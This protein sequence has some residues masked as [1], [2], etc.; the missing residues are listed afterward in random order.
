MSLYRRPGSPYWWTRFTVGGCKVRRST[1]TANKKQAGQVETRLREQLWGRAHVGLRTWQEACIRWLEDH[2]DK[3]SLDRDRSIIEWSLPHL[4]DVYLHEIDRDRLD[5]L[6]KVKAR[7]TSK[8]TANRHLSLIRA[9]LNA[10]ADEWGWITVAPKVPMFPQPPAEP[11]WL[12]R[13]EFARLLDY[14]PPHTRQLARFAVATGLRRTNIT[15]L[16]WSQV[17]LK[18]QHLHIKAS[19]AKG[20]K[21][22]PVPLTDSAL[23]ILA[24]QEGQHDVWVF[25]YQGAP[26]N[27]V[28]TKAWRKA[29]TAIGRPTLRFHDL[30]HTWASWHVQAG[31]PLHAL[32]ALGGWADLSMVQRYAHLDSSSL[33]HYAQSA[34]LQGHNTGT[35]SGDGKGKVA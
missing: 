17:D 22:I 34:D 16:R 18:R 13:E 5:E 32:Q 10:A 30:R 4:R 1:E 24:E 9:V 33:S 3:R 35:L 2:E 25:T 27:Q 8:A 20:K 11:Q 15:H 19:E 31:T 26:V 23:T 6:R 21:A 7:Q 14:L 12:T 28:V 29:V